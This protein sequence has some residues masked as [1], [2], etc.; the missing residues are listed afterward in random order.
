MTELELLRKEHQALGDKIEVLANSLAHKKTAFEV[1][2]WYVD[3]NRPN[4]LLCYGPIE[5]DVFG[6]WQGGWGTGYDFFNIEPKQPCRL[7]TDDEVKAMLVREA[8]KRFIPGT[9][10]F[11]VN[12]I[13]RCLSKTKNITNEL[14]Y[15]Y[16][17]ESDCL[18]QYGAGN[19]YA[20]GIWA[21]IIKDEAITIGGYNARYEGNVVRFGC[22]AFSLEQVNQL[23][24]SVITF[25]LDDFLCFN[26]KVTKADIQKIL[27]GFPS[28]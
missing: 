21:E 17:P 24:S 9:K 16:N 12:S 5:Y 20:A 6:F 11:L 15:V 8:E 26:C 25:G 22:K 2:K 23:M 1:G 18:C 10:V 14:D 3:V 7:A 4:N 19:V 27:S 28:L 13:D